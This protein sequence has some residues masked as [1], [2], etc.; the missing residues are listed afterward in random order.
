MALNEELLEILVCPRCKQ[1]LELTE[2]NDALVCRKCK[3][4][5]PVEDD[6]PVLIESAAEPLD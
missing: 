4:R 3:L 6:I 2:S 1:R 5:Y